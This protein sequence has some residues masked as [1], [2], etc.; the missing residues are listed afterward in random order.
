M[1]PQGGQSDA[2]WT[3]RGPGTLWRLDAGAVLDAAGTRT[4]RASVILQFDAPPTPTGHEP[5]I[6]RGR[7]VPTGAA[8]VVVV[9]KREEVDSHPSARAEGLLRVDLSDCLLIPGLVNAHTH[10]DLTHIGPVGFDEAG[11]FVGWVDMVRA[12]RHADAEQIRA[13]VTLGLRQSLLGGVVAVGDIAGAP[14]AVPQIA[15]LD[16][17]AGSPVAGVSFVEFFAI[18]LPETAS[19]ERLAA[20]LAEHAGE[21]RGA[22]RLGLQPHAT[23]TVSVPS[24]LW[25]VEQAKARG[26]ALMTHVAETP[27]EQ[28]FIAEGRGPQRELLERLKVWDDS[29]LEYVGKGRTPVAHLEPALAA[30]QDAGQ[31]FAAVHVNDASDADLTI[32]ARTGAIVCYC[33]RASAYFGAERSFGPHRYR[34]MARAGISVALGTDSLVNLPK[35]AAGERGIGMSTLD[36]MRLLHRRD[37]ASAMELLTM[38]TLNGARALGLDERAFAFAPGVPIQGVV[39]LKLEGAPTSAEDALAGALRGA[40]CPQLLYIR[41]GSCQTGIDRRLST[42]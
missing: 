30:A 22:A 27:E 16:A 2:V 14:R 26:L 38:A 5:L 18:G 25:S 20:F 35:D 12:G 8:R 36:E 6:V 21:A 11:G 13:S 15:P 34:D 39:A 31:P 17:L 10:L 42:I 9:G 28:R 24:F 1:N 33:P 19:R 23:N 40:S 29:I 37:G 7:V 32:L 3:G 41:N 4:T